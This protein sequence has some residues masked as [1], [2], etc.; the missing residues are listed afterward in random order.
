MGEDEWALLRLF[1]GD[2]VD[3]GCF[4]CEVVFY[5][6]SAKVRHSDSFFMLR[7]NHECRHLTAYFNFK[8][9]TLYKYDQD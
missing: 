3:R 9:E 5:M 1:L 2:F 7:G 6:A 4:G 8:A